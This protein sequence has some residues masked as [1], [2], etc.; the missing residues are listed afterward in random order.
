MALSRRWHIAAVTVALIAHYDDL[1]ASTRERAPRLAAAGLLLGRLR[2][3]HFRGQRSDVGEGPVDSA[4]GDVRRGSPGLPQ[5]WISAHRAFGG[6]PP[7]GS[8]HPN[9]VRTGRL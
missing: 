2:L 5:A 9:H 8:V 3:L 1:R 4:G 7:A 6:R